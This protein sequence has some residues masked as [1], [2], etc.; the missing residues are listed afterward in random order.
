MGQYYHLSILSTEK[1]SAKNRKKVIAYLRPINYGCGLKL[2]EFSYINNRC[3]GA[4]ETLIN[5]ENGKYC[6]Y[7]IIA[8]GDYADDEPFTLN[9]EKV[10]L[11]HLSKMFGECLEN[12]PKSHYRFV[13]NED[14]KEYVDTN[15]VKTDSC[16][17][18]VHPLPLLIADGNGRGCGDYHGIDKEKVGIWKRQVV[19]VSNNIPKDY[20]ELE[21]NFLEEY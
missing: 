5:D 20:K 15:K 14:T 3:V 10:N 6:G 16:G 11:Y 1:K 18:R 7:P 8:C 4:F 12:I 2:T 19:Y 9:K 13:I 21:V 17:F